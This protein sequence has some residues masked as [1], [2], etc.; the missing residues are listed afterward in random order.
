MK[1]W[2][3]VAIYWVIWWI[4][5]FAILPIGVRNAHEAG[6]KIGEGHDAG[7]PVAHGLVKKALINTVVATAVF[8]GVYFAYTRGVLGT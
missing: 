5:L 3:M 1:P 6:E 4:T 2:S 7:A 8:V